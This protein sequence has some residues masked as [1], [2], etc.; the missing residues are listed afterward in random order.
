MVQGL[1]FASAGAMIVA[2]FARACLIIWAERRY[3]LTWPRAHE[4]YHWSKETRAARARFMHDLM[5]AEQGATGGVPVARLIKGSTV[6]NYLL[7]VILICLLLIEASGGK[8]VVWRRSV[9]VFANILLA[10]KIY[11]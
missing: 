10:A 9:G 3:G 4:I 1:I 7:I 8:A 2:M 6:T 11:E 5:K